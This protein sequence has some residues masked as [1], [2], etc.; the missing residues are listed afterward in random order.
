MQPSLKKPA[1]DH[2]STLSL[3]I[4]SS[5]LILA[6]FSFLDY[7]FPEGPMD[8]I[9]KLLRKGDLRTKGRS[10]DVVKLA[11]RR[12]ELFKDVVAAILDDD[13]GV[14]MRA[15]DAVEKISRIHPEW[16]KPHKK[17]FL[18]AITKIKQQE[19]RWHVAQM[20][21]RFKLTTP[22]RRAVFVLMQ[23]Y[24]DDESSIV[25]TCAM[26][27]LA[28]IA[29]QDGRYLPDVMK[30]VEKHMKNGSPAMKARGRKLMGILNK[31]DGR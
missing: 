25:R 14:R 3:F 30:I 15:A 19:V 12:P 31:A 17:L 24:L 27:A 4:I 18:R 8:Q 13:R 5:F 22:E 23:T 2:G 1:N 29:L 9:T 16:L 21:P 26:Q 11:L 6:I 10:E 20:L 7:V 28:D